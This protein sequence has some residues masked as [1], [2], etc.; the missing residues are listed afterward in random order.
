MSF[1]EL[2]LSEPLCRA[3]EAERYER[4]TPIQQKAIPVVLEG[5]DLL[6]CA[7]TGTGKTA[8]FVLPILQRLATSPREGRIRALVLAPTEL[9]AQIDERVSAYG[10]HLGLRHTVIFGGVN[11]NRQTR[12][13]RPAPAVLVATPG[14]LL[15]LVNQRFIDLS[16]MEVL[17]LDEADRMLDMGFIH[18]VR[19]IV[20]LTPKS[21]QTLLFSATM[22]RDIVDLARNI[23]KDPARIDV[24][25]ASATPDLVQQS[26]YFVARADKRRLLER[27]LRNVDIDRALVFTRTKR[28]ASRVARLLDGAGIRADAFH[29]DKTQG[30]RIRALSDFKRGST[31]VLVATDIA[32]RGIDVD[33][34]SHVINYDMPDAAESY[35]HR[36]GRTGRAGASGIALSF[37]DHDERGVLKDIERLMGRR[38]PVAND[39]S[40]ADQ[41]HDGPPRDRGAA[42]SRDAVRNQPPRGNVPECNSSR[43]P[44]SPAPPKQRSPRWRQRSARRRRLRLVRT[45]DCLRSSWRRS[46][47]P[48]QRA[49]SAPSST[50]GTSPS[51]AIVRTRRPAPG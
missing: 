38:V 16:G 10:R 7:Q 30:A 26:V 11:Q 2:K 22:P 33:G 47:R 35:V 13:L 31:R 1:S 9:A 28:G 20:A 27:L 24:M 21:R 3:L 32:A 17:V 40:G 34:V 43:S 44:N 14:R 5:K 46:I 18:D 48:G 42:P 36:I 51:R 45:A 39:G 29:G 4:P 23:L 41:M 15:D 25:P 19:K 49:R 50:P 12:A 8:A 6:G 37:C